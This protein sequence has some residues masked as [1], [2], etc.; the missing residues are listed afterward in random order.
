MAA[1]RQVGSGTGC[2]A[3]AKDATTACRRRS[4]NV[5][6]SA[7]NVPNNAQDPDSWPSSKIKQSRIACVPAGSNSWAASRIAYWQCATGDLDCRSKIL[8]WCHA[9]GQLVVEVVL[10]PKLQLA[11]CAVPQLYHNGWLGKRSTCSSSRSSFHYS[12]SC[13][14]SPC[15]G[16]NRTL[17]PLAYIFLRASVLLPMLSIVVR[18]ISA[19]VI[20]CSTYETKSC[21]PREK[22]T[23]LL[24]ACPRTQISQL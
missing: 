11:E 13:I 22:I 15:G 12:Q 21:L 2:A 7:T 17:S 8:P 3:L 20:W 1:F 18:R 5:A 19:L 9:C 10:Q 24:W 16:K 23:T 6:D 14:L 4:K